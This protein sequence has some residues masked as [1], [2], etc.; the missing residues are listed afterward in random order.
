MIRMGRARSSLIGAS[1]GQ[2]RNTIQDAFTGLSER[3]DEFGEPGSHMFKAQGKVVRS[4]N[5]SETDPAPV[6]SKLRKCSLLVLLEGINRHLFSPV[7]R[8]PYERA[9]LHRE[10]LTGGKATASLQ[11][12]ESPH[13]GQPDALST[14]LRQNLDLVDHED[15][16]SDDATKLAINSLLQLLGFGVE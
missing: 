9:E 5:S 2:I 4:S 12:E 11:I 14:M 13:S 6:G 10:W 16:P 1:T 15:I 3:R 8:V 7:L